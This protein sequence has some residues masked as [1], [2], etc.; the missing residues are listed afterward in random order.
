VT[1][2]VRNEP[3]KH[4]GKFHRREC[5]SDTDPKD[6]SGSEFSV[7]MDRAV[8]GSVSDSVFSDGCYVGDSGFTGEADG[9]I[10]AEEAGPVFKCII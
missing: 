7:V 8:V 10:R 3:N 2:I 4:A 6:G 9:W 1:N 5:Y